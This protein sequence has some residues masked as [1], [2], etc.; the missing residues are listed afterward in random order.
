MFGDIGH[1]SVLLLVGILMCI[2]NQPIRKA[3]PGAAGILKG[4]YLFLL[5]GLFATFCGLCYN[6]FMA[7]P[8]NLFDTCYDI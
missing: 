1:G 4:R 8:L 7:I 5:M 2:F 3:A 6:D